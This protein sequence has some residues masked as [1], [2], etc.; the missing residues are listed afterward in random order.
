MYNLISKKLNLN[1]SWYIMTSIFLIAC[2]SSCNDN[3]LVIAK[4]GNSN[5]EIVLS[6]LESEKTV[7]T[8]TILAD[9]IEKIGSV[10]L[11]VVKENTESTNGRSIFV[12]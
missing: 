10:A 1:S 6:D 8:A 12:R 2:F 3:K 5:Y 9:Y 11:P 7:E 4:N